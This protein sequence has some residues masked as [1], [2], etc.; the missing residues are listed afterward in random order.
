MF[1]HIVMWNIKEGYDKKEVH[2]KIRNDLRSL[3]DIIPEIHDLDVLENVV[4]G[5]NRDIILLSEF[6]TEEDFLV[7]K[8]H[9]EHL[10]VVEYIKSTC[11]DRSVID[12]K[13]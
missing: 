3:M 13:E 8:T 5:N 6:E 2:H 11:M 10:K 9:P 4:E 7:Y 1:K 12:I